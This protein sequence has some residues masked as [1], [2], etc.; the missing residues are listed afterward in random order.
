M[1][2]YQ[3]K[4]MTLEDAR[5]ASEAARAEGK[6]VVMANGCFDLLHGGHISYLDDSKAQGDFLIVAVLVTGIFSV[7]DDD[8]LVFPVQVIP[9]NPADFTQPPCTGDSKIH[10]V[11]H[12]YLLALFS[13][14]AL[15]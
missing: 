2:D 6:R 9:G 12:G 8:G 11:S 13:A 3:K 4:I 5:Q 15:A 14:P 10:N 1:K 7:T